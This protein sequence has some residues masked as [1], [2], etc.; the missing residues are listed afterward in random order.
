M[1]REKSEKK[2]QQNQASQP[3]PQST[4]QSNDTHHNQTYRIKYTGRSRVPK[5]AWPHHQ[6]K[7]MYDAPRA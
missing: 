2:R 4:D 3:S 7:E 6:G 1:V 5:T